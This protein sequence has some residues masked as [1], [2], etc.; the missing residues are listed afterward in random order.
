M[1]QGDLH[2]G[3]P[4]RRRCICF[5]I[6]S[7]LLRHEILLLSDR[8]GSRF[9]VNHQWCLIMCQA[10][11]SIFSPNGNSSRS[12]LG[13]FWSSL[14]SYRHHTSSRETEMARI[15]DSPCRVRCACFLGTKVICA[16]N[17]DRRS[18]LSNGIGHSG[19]YKNSCVTR[20]LPT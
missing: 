3:F 1:F 10:W 2:S 9:E 17:L 4:C 7:G 6:P 16:P 18:L 8:A 5:W 19:K 12:L 11:R 20:W 13:F 15:I 14:L